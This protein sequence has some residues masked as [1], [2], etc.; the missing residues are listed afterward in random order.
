MNQVNP[1]SIEP[2]ESYCVACEEALN[3]YLDGELTFD[4][5][6]LLFARLAVCTACREQFNA[7]MAFR[8]V[9][10]EDRFDL[11]PK[12]EETFYRKLAE[13]R[14]SPHRVDRFA[15]R[16]PLWEVRKPYSVRSV[17]FVVAISFFLGVQFRDSAMQRFFSTGGIQ[18]QVEYVSLRRAGTNLPHFFIYPGLTVEFDTLSV[19]DDPEDPPPHS[20]TQGS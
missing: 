14:R 11:P 12:A 8:M 10:R 13:R 7:V 17:A 20:R 4:A 19:P 15:D 3:L 5:Q 1:L 2:D 6:P 9:T 18:Q 16:R